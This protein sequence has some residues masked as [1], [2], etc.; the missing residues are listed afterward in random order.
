M[1]EQIN[2]PGKE[3]NLNKMEISNLSDT[4][5]KTLVIRTL[6]ELREDLNNVKK[7]QSETKNTLTEIKDSLLGNNSRVNEVENQINDWEHKDA[8]QTNK[9]T[10][11][12]EQQEVK[13]IQKKQGQCKQPM[14]QLQAFQH[15]HHRCARRRTER[16]RN[17]K[18]I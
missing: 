2:T 14:G 1:K 7:I 5:Y 3:K 13:R 15:L 16:A 18:S 6:K 8:K 11:H 12:S 17:W 10:P 4:E 9:K